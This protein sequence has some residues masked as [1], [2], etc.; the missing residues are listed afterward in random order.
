MNRSLILV[1]AGCGAQSDRS[2]PL[3]APPAIEESRTPRDQF[4]GGE[5][6]QEPKVEAAP[7]VGGASAD[8]PASV[9]LAA[10]KPSDPGDHEFDKN[11]GKARIKEGED[12]QAPA[13]TRSWFPE[14]FLWIPLVET[15]ASGVA[16]VPVAVPDSLTTWR[17]L[18]LA[19]TNGGAQG[20]T[21]ANF[22]ST[23]PAYVDLVVP[24][25]VFA[26]DELALPI[27]VVNTTNAGIVQSLAIAVD[28]G[29]GAGAGSLT[30]GP[31]GSAT[32][33]LSFRAG[34]PGMATIRADFGSID[35]I[36]RTLPV[37]PVGRM[38][39][40]TQA[41]AVSSQKPL[42]TSAVPG[43]EYGE[44]V[45]TA[46][47]GALS[48]VRAEL[49]GPPVWIERAPIWGGGNPLGDAAYKYA[50]AQAGAA[51]DPAEAK[52]ET[53]RAM[54]LS[55][56]QPLSRAGR[57]PDTATACL[58]AETLRDAPADTLDGRLA[59]RMVETVVDSQAPDGTWL[60]GAM[61]IDSTLL[62]TALCARAVS[63]QPAAR[64]RAEGAFDRHQ[65]RLVDPTLAAYALASGT[66]TDADLRARLTETIT[67]G[68]KTGESGTRYLEGAGL[69]RADGHWV[70]SAEATAAGALALSADV[71]LAS[72]LATSLLGMH[73]AW[74]G[75]SDGEGDLLVLRALSAALPNPDGPVPE[76]MVSVDG[77]EVARATVNP[78]EPHKAITV[79]VP[80]ATSN[81]H[82]VLVT[83]GGPGLSFTLST[84]AWV[85]WG[86]A[87][88]GV[89]EIGVE[90]PDRLT[91]GSVARV[92]VRVATPSSV[93]SNLILGLPAGV[94]ADP[95]GMDRLV[96]EG[97]FTSWTGSEG[98]VL[99]RG[100]AG[101]G[102]AGEIPVVAA[103]AGRVSAAPSRLVA[104]DSG[105]ELFV[106]PPSRWAI[107][108]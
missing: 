84:R 50:L 63:D 44:L 29:T 94:R 77:A 18:A 42:T 48:V 52:P 73:R 75:W 92:R 32:R 16:T 55:A 59:T 65:E 5:G 62:E 60:T 79:R 20:G 28:G 71:G 14:S 82:Q 74:G 51:L 88:S 98:S 99:V 41:G 36:E 37:R 72:E 10:A 54:R 58:I 85:P 107:G 39:E 15:D 61:D 57:A 70:T 66:I 49:D 21:E 104:E 19:Q 9:R 68:L 12:G 34:A 45:L 90:A 1:L 101:G 8:A 17:V 67:K 24:G 97:A 25:S 108:G 53:L 38:V 95:E 31:G 69:R 2:E 56:W 6:G 91:V 105:D 4:W 23:L 22:L 7:P 64:L 3:A 76:L 11:D 46:W 100:F 33:T 102:W 86:P 81:A 30:V 35:S 106:L 87:E 83:G 26:G 47:P 80:V 103:L 96:R 43:G 27:Q 13:P 93:R 89:A 40:S 78:T